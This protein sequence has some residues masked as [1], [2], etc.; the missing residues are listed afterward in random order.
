MLCEIATGNAMSSLHH[1]FEWHE[2][3][4]EG[5][6]AYTGGDYRQQQQPD[7][8][9]H[10]PLGLGSERGCFRVYIVSGELLPLTAYASGGVPSFLLDLVDKIT[11]NL[12]RGGEPLQGL[13]LL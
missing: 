12:C 5:A 13:C 6:H 10:L 11:G 9:P 2:A 1:K 4:D 7:G 3:T 8:E